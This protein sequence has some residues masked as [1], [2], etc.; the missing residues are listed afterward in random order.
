MHSL[1]VFT[2]KEL[3]EQVKTFKGLVI[4][5]VLLV[6]GMT[7]P[8]LAKL[9]PEIIKMASAQIKIQMPDV[10]Y[11][12]AYAQ[13][14]KNISQM[15]LL[16]VILVFCGSIV[17]ETTKGTAQ[18]MLTKRLSRSSFI[19]SKFL[20]CVV[21][22]TIS[23]AVSAALCICYTV[24]LFPT[25]KPSNLVLSLLCMWL[26]GIILIAAT[27]LSSSV[28]GNYALAA[29]GSFALWGL[30][31]LLSIFTKLK[32]YLPSSLS[33]ENMALIS[34]SVKASTMLFP[35][36]TGILLTAI[37]LLLSCLIFSKREL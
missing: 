22:W 3:R 30:I 28:F 24:Y 20:S 15:A 5:I 25:G 9:T 13:F 11:L 4:F 18:I 34:G 16:V 32:D 27:L 6:F 31:T 17:T 1:I 36:I 19:V 7:S 33:S 8:L 10:T 12:D 37:F 35:I 21:V 29:V 23:Y 26:F 2:V 14:F